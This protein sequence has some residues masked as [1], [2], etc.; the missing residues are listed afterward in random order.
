MTPDF[1]DGTMR[2]LLIES[3]P[4]DA[5]TFAE[6]L[7]H[8]CSCFEVTIEHDLDQALARPDDDAW[9]LILVDQVFP[10]C[11]GLETFDRALARW[12]EAAIVVLA[13][14]ADESMAQLAVSKGAQDYL[15]KKDMTDRGLDRALRYSMER[16]R[17]AAERRFLVH[18]LEQSRRLEAMGQLAAGVAHEINTPTQYVSDNVRFLEE[19]VRDLAGVL[20]TLR[21]SADAGEAVSADE[22][23]ARLD[24]ADLDYLLDEIPRA[25]EQSLGGLTQ[26]ARIVRAMKECSHPSSEDKTPADLNACLES[27]VLVSTNEWKYVATLRTDYDDALPHVVCLPGE[28]NQVFLNLIV[29]AAHAIADVVDENSGER[30]EITVTTRALDPDWVEV[31]IS[32]T[33]GGIPA[34]IEN[35]VFEPFFTTKEVGQGTGQGLAIAHNVIVQRH[36]GKIGFESRPGKGTEFFVRLPVRPEVLEEAETR[37]EVCTV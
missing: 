9:D 14:F 1:A 10:G 33:G 13:P 7:R 16:H 27:T 32:D 4:R 6:K 2:I 37:D 35:R 24:D 22:L 29:N 20:T 8:A 15:V 19:A 11:T 5:R 18:E 17:A 28:L 3:D 31:R 12:P 26:I 34:S 36:G 30:G 23:K 25:V 21:K